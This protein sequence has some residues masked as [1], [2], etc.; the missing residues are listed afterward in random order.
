MFNRT[1]EGAELY[2]VQR[3]LCLKWGVSACSTNAFAGDVTFSQPSY[4]VRE[5]DEY[6]DLTVTRSGGDDGYLVIAYT[7]TEH[8]V[9][10]TPAVLPSDWDSKTTTE[11]EA[12]LAATNASFGAQENV[13]FVTVQGELVWG[14]A[15]TGDKV[16]AVPLVDNEALQ[17]PRAF[18][19]SLSVVESVVP[20]GVLGVT[21]VVVRDAYCAAGESAGCVPYRPTTWSTI[22]VQDGAAGGGYNVVV[23]GTGFSSGYSCV[24]YAEES[25]PAALQVG[26]TTSVVHAVY[27][28]TTQVQCQVPTWTSAD[29]DANLKVLE[30]GLSIENR[31][32]AS[33][34]RFNLP[35]VTSIEPGNQAPTASTNVTITGSGFGMVDSSPLAWVG[36]TSYEATWVSDTSITTTFGPGTGVQPTCVSFGDVKGC[37]VRLD[38]TIANISLADWNADPTFEQDLLQAIADLAGV[39]VEDVSVAQVVDNTG[40]SRRLLQASGIQIVVYIVVTT[41]VDANNIVTST[42]SL[43]V[44]VLAN[45]SYVLST[46]VGLGAS[47]SYDAPIVTGVTPNAHPPGLSGDQASIVLTGSNFGGYDSSPVVRIGDTNCLSTTWASDNQ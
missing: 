25:L 19:C 6:A 9:L 21:D 36:A 5:T 27:V 45:S 7:C 40:G 41:D 8:P 31:L 30:N 26:H 1:L 24:W 11:Q 46:T 15:E 44:V 17:V 16:F 32:G 2:T 38:L 34:F 42:Q 3:A 12:I 13:D 43:Y 47:L 4:V 39:P 35:L 22:D 37:A 20:T 33:G 10:P 14:H 28:S 23:S 18:Q 29:R